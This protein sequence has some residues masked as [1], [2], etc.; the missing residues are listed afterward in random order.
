MLEKA[1]GGG[2]AGVHARGRF[3]D[4]PG[5]AGFLQGGRGGEGVRTATATSSAHKIARGKAHRFTHTHRRGD[6]AGA[7][8]RRRG[9]RRGGGT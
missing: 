9:E 4:A 2:R 7:F 1:H 5:S 8:W 6:D 3:L